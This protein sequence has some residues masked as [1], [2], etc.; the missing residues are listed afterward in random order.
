MMSMR[1]TTGQV[2]VLAYCYAVEILGFSEIRSLCG[3]DS[4]IFKKPYPAGN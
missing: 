4:V 3:K 2:Q 1:K